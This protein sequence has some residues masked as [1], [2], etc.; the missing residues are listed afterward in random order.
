MFKTFAQKNC[1]TVNT[2]LEKGLCEDLKSLDPFPS[3][4]IL[5]SFTVFER[6]LKTDA[7]TMWFDK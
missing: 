2:E 5:S 7:I 1:S 3:F 4:K 6:L